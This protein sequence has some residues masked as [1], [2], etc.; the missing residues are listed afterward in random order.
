MSHPH[1]DAAASVLMIGVEGQNLTPQEVRFLQTVKPAGVILFGRNINQENHLQVRELTTSIQ[2]YCSDVNSSPIRLIAIDQEGGRVSRLKAD[3]PNQGPALS[4]A[5]GRWDQNGLEDITAYGKAIGVRL[6]QLGININF[7]P[8]VDLLTE[9]LNTALGD[10]CFGK[11]P[12]QVIP[13]ARAFLSGLQSVPVLGCLK[14]FPGQGDAAIDTHLGTAMVNLPESLLWERE[15]AP[16]RELIHQG[17]GTQETSAE[18]PAAAHAGVPLVRM[19]MVAHCI[20]P[21]W[22][23]REASRSP[24]IMGQLLR[25]RL[26]FEGVIVTD[27]MLMGAIPQSDKEWCQA[28]IDSVRAGADLVLVCKGLDRAQI[29]Y[30]CLTEEA[31]KDSEF[32]HRLQDAALRVTRLQKHVGTRL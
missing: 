1:F 21:A 13:R 6:N 19:V 16:F 30:Q 18:A 27:D 5:Q 17:N 14:H 7:A 2:D 15:L 11:T 9:P 22:S 3:F 24:E 12:E 8:V 26:G 31:D 25:H 4:L 20:Y 29:A 23:P 10:R 28:L 32:A